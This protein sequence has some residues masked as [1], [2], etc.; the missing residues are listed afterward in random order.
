[1]R[2][3]VTR[4]ADDAA[5]LAR[6]LAALGHE[7]LIE[8]LLRV[9]PLD[10]ATLGL[11][12][13][14]G[15]VV[16]SRQALRA[17]ARNAAALIA[18]RPLPIFTVGGATAQEARDL[19]CLTVIEGPGQAAGLVPLIATRAARLEGRLLHLAGERLAFDLQAALAAE[20]VDM[21]T[22]V[23]YR[24]MPAR[25]LSPA[26]LT[27]LRTPILNGVLLLS[28]ETARTWV[29]LLAHHGLEI[30]ALSLTHYCLSPAVAAAL[31]PLPQARSRT[32]LSPSVEDLLALLTEPAAK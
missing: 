23:V 2:L 1:M 18:A 13:I 29:R 27:A 25:E 32:A 21:E 26:T 19:G 10:D 7:A 30:E 28:P 31:G 16:T 15:L 17:L 4:P 8:P 9:E 6:R 3:L 20:G 5:E 12:G 14:G 11:A 22:R 24:T